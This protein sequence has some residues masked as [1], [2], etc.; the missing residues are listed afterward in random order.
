MS[1]DAEASVVV[2]RRIS[3]L[4]ARLRKV[5]RVILLEFDR[6]NMK[7]LDIIPLSNLTS[8]LTEVESGDA[9]INGRVE[10]YSCASSIDAY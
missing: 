10:C 5:S 9:V 1:Q 2:V 7:F 6:T 8:L 4:H 3:Q